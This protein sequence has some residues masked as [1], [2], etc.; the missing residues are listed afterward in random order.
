MKTNNVLRCFFAEII[1]ILT[2]LIEVVVG[3]VE[4]QSN[5]TI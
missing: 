5:T 2:N 4:I 1:Q 3:T